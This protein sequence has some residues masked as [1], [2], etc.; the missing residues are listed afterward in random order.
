MS[1]NHVFHF[2]EL[3]KRVEPIKEVVEEEFV[4]LTK[5]AEKRE[6]VNIVSEMQNITGGVIVRSFFGKEL[7]KEY[8]DNSD[9]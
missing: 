3:Q 4:K 6:I 8:V 5:K 2:A 7:M 9:Y 1:L